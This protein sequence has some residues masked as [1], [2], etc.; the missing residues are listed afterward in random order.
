[1]GQGVKPTG[2]AHLSEATQDHP[3]KPAVLQASMDMFS[4]AAAFVDRLTF[5]ALRLGGAMNAA[6]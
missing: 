5:F 6:V 1:V 3:A 2:D 4:V